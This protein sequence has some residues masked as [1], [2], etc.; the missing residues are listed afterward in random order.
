M[1][2]RLKD[3]NSFSAGTKVIFYRTRE[4][5]LLPYFC[6]EN[7][8]VYCI[9]IEGLLLNMGV[10]EYRYQ[11][12]RLFIDSSKRSLKCVLILNGNQYASVLIGHS[13]KLKKG[14]NNI[15][16]LLE[17]LKYHEHRWLICIDL[18]MINFLLHQQSGYTKNPCFM[19][20]WNSHARDVHW[21]RKKWPLR[22]DMTVNEPI[23]LM[24]LLYPETKLLFFL[25]T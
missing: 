2:S 3:K 11:D 16:L 19:S 20:L 14:Y 13:T 17:K 5:E 18:K 6:L 7:G 1:A 9:D 22:I 15:E 12:W 23:S 24:S 21:E 10:P 4:K 8:F 25:S